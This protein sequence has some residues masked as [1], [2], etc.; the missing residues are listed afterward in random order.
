M[1]RQIKQFQQTEINRKGAATLHPFLSPNPNSRH[2]LRPSYVVVQTV[3]PTM[4]DF[5]EAGAGTAF[6][7]NCLK[8]K[9]NT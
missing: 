6:Q 1:S 7:I 8:Q 2:D 9:K 4:Y 5:E 3:T